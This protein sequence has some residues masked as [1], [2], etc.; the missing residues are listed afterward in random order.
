MGVGNFGEKGEQ[1]IIIRVVGRATQKGKE[2]S[3]YSLECALGSPCKEFLIV[4][5]PKPTIQIGCE[6]KNRL[7]PL[8]IFLVRIIGAI[9]GNLL[10]ICGSAE[11][12]TGEMSKSQARSYAE[13]GSRRSFRG[14]TW[15]ERRQK[16]R[17][18]RD[19][20]QA[21]GQSS[22]GEGSFQTY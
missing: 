17:E 9:C 21:E 7:S 14:S 3:S 8:T 6:P 10:R 16:M 12:R 2:W 19:Y 11:M 22:L 20:E 18:D 5:N 13:N 1:R 4:G 15:W